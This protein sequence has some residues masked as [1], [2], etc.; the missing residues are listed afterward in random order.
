MKPPFSYEVIDPDA[1]GR[2]HYRIRD[3]NDDRISTSYVEEN[4]REIVRL[5]N[6]GARLDAP[7]GGCVMGMPAPGSRALFPDELAA[8]VEEAKRW[9]EAHKQAITFDQEDLDRLAAR[10]K[11]RFEW[12]G[13]IKLL[14]LGNYYRCLAEK[15]NSDTLDNRCQELYDTVLAELDKLQGQDEGFRFEYDDAGFIVKRL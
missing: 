7:S 4:A 15:V 2:R 5:M 9:E 14:P 10:V 6:L 13:G 8:M 1:D 11:N 3:A 12:D